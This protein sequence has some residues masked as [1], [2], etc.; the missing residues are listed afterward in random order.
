MALKAH[1]G[2]LQRAFLAYNRVSRGMTL[3]VRAVLVR[4][5]EV[6]LVK[7]TYLPGWY[8]PGGGVEAGETFGAALEREV[9]EEAGVRLTGRPE[10]FGL[11]RNAHASRRDHVALYVCRDWEPSPT[12]HVPNREIKAAQLFPMAELPADA[13]AG[14]RDRIAE[15]FSGRPQSADW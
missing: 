3:G 13:N 1:Q 2:V 7:H 10:L 14:T 5:E 8:F 15:I 9:W 12:A 11:Y 4:G 6:M